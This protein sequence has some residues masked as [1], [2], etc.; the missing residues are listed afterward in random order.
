MPAATRC[1]ADFLRAPRR[2]GL[3]LL[4]ALGLAAAV[5]VGAP[6]AGAKSTPALRI[7]VTNDDGV[8]GYA[9]F[10]PLGKAS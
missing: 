1:T 8:G 9:V 2:A 5:S 7:L 3:G 10:S 6:Q 4:T